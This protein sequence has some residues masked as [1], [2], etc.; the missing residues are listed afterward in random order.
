MV[1]ELTNTVQNLKAMWKN[2]IKTTYR[3]LI[4]NKVY[5]AI[6]ILG[7]TI[8]I[9]CFSII[10]LYVENEFSF[11]Q[12]HA[13]ESYRFLYTEQ[14]GDGESRTFGTIND[15]SHDAF[16]DK[17]SGIKDVILLRDY[18][19]GPLLVEYKDVEF[20]TRE[21]LFAEPDFFDYFDFELLQGNPETAL[22]KPNNV[23]LTKSTAKKI[24]GDANPMGELIKYSGGMN[25]TLQVTGVVED[26]EN[27]HFDFDFLMNFDLKTESGFVMMREGF[28]VYGYYKLEAGV[29]PADVAL[30]AKNYYLDFYK[31]RPD[32]IESLSR[33]SYSFQSIYDI[34]FGS[35]GVILDDGMRKGSKQNVKILAVIGLFILLVACMNYINASTAKAISRSKEI[36]VRKV[37]GAFKV[38]LITQFMS[39]AFFI[40]LAA[41]V[42]SVLLTDISLPAFESLMQTELRYSLLDNPNYL[43]GLISVLIS[44]TLISGTYPAM[45]LSS[46]RPSESLKNQSDNGLLKG[47]GLRKLLIGV[48]LFFT[49]V[50]ISGVL[51]IVKQTKFL[52]SMDLGFSKEDILIVPNSSPKVNEQLTTYKNE[53]LKNPYIYEATIGMDVLGFGSTNNSGMVILEGTNPQE[54]PVASFFSVGMDFIDIQ[55]IEVMDGRSFN[56][57]LGTDSMAIIVNEAFIKAY[58]SEEVLGKKVRLW[59]TE[60]DPRTVIGVVED[61]NFM[62]LHNKVSPAIF[63][64]SRGTNWFWTLKIDPEHKKEAVNHAR[65][66]WEAV[67]STY[68]FDHMFLEDKLDDF[69]GDENRLES[70]IEVFALICV[71]ISCL[72]L[73]GMTA[74]VLERKTKE[75]GIRKVLGAQLNHLVWMINKKFIS[76]LIIA[77]VIAIPIVYYMI[78][79][80]LDGFAYQMNIGFMSFI[81]SSAIV[82]AIVL[83][84]VS[85]QAI[86]AALSN[87]IRTLRSE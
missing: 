52:N 29:E 30:R 70:A 18:G 78:S 45:V 19:A 85:W 38:Q 61:F 8:G 56:S 14:T 73:Y 4:R 10:M 2:Y 44:V 83:V 33:E 76:I 24:F 23:I 25:F 3:N 81:W 64:V 20:K 51:L 37:F 15:E 77:A 84:T 9:T 75:I 74:F 59:N 13:N 55:E 32:V 71:F 66:S 17:V 46:F 21:M 63:M 82:L 53:L 57:S 36:G 47:N 12:F 67:D 49:M 1:S 62:S 87:P 48:Q 54:A 41:V 68:P 6:N 65:V 31:D 79:I 34:Y 27:S 43:I 16:A 11:D 39:E 5:S 22:S 60:Q 86:R 7:L 50:L 72:G 40:T 69:Y 35:A 80:W 26:P 58:G 28:S 42:L